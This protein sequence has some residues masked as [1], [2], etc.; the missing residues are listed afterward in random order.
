MFRTGVWVYIP[1]AACLW[2]TGRTAVSNLF[3]G[4][5]S[6]LTQWTGSSPVPCDIYIDADVRSCMSL[7]SDGLITLPDDRGARSS[8]AG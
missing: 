4:M 8:A 3:S 7:N 2:R 5:G 1:M 6:S